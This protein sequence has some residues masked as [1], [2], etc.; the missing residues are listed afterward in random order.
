[1]NDQ[2]K[3]RILIADDH[4]IVLDGLKV[5]LEMED[6]IEIVAEANSG[7]EVLE[8]IEKQTIDVFVLDISMED[9]DGVKTTQALFRRIKDP[10]IIILTMHSKKQYI[11]DLMEEGVSGYIFKSRSGEELVEAINNVYHGK[12]HFGE[13][14]INVATQSGRYYS[15]TITQI[16]QREKEVLR[17]IGQ[18][19]TTKEI[20]KEL[21]IA[22]TTVE[23]HVRNLLAKLELSSKMHLVRYAVENDYI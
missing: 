8:I 22:P 13:E 12:K 9:L 23:T 5:L 4:Q 2:S 7:R 15:S 11:L 20:G 19:K 17:L 18:C 6:N 21:F 16:S 1:M 14:V 3:I 10:K